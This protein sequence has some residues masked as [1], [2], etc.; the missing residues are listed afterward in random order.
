MPFGIP[1]L[2]WTTPRWN[3]MKTRARACGNPA[4]DPPLT[5]LM[6]LDVVQTQIGE[7]IQVLRRDRERQMAANAAISSELDG[8]AIMPP[9]QQIARLQNLSN[10]I[11][12]Q[13]LHDR[14]VAQ[15]ERAQNLAAEQD[16]AAQRTAEADAAAQK[17]TA[18]QQA[19][20]QGKQEAIA[21]Q[22]EIK[23]ERAAVAEQA[24][25][26]E[27]V[28]QE[29]TT[30]RQ[31]LV[32]AQQQRQALVPDQAQLDQQRERDEAEL[33]ELRQQRAT[34]EEQSN[35]VEQ[36]NQEN[37]AQQVALALI[38]ENSDELASLR[39]PTSMLDAKIMFPDGH[40]S[41]GPFVT[42]REFISVLL[43]RKET[44]ISGISAYGGTRQGFSIKRP[45]APM[46]AIV[47]RQDGN[48]LY[49]D[50]GGQGDSVQKMNDNEQMS[51]ATVLAVFYQ[52]TLKQK[53]D[54]SLIR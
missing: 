44:K 13:P 36:Q 3:A 54:A 6:A 1:Y 29:A 24:R 14:V 28:R 21:R 8:I 42:Y 38:A 9:K 30:A 47:F 23:R 35:A 46:A 34:L 40:G 12:G 25:R 39:F 11:A 19:I 17:L 32:Q 45:E 31:R 2:E 33:R 48:E 27:V 52:E 16:D 10:Q 49:L 4:I 53:V 37:R 20:E 18:V 22:A 26:T 15:L 5:A 51:M 50:A 41:Y 43:A 7:R